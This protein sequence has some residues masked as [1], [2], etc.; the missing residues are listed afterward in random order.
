LLSSSSVCSTLP[1]EPLQFVAL[2][3]E[4][5]EALPDFADSDPLP[6]PELV[7]VLVA[8]V[9]PP[10]AVALL[11]LVAF[12]L[13]VAVCDESPP[14]PPVALLV[15]LPVFDASAVL[16]L[17][18]ALLLEV[19]QASPGSLQSPVSKATESVPTIVSS[20]RI[21][22]SS[23]PFSVPASLHASPPLLSYFCSCFTDPL[24]RLSL[25]A[26]VE[27]HA[28]ALPDVALSDP[29]PEPV[30]EAELLLLV[31]PPVALAV[32][33]LVALPLP[34]ASWLESPPLPPVAEL[35]ASPELPDV[36]VELLLPP[37]LLELESALG[38]LG[39][40]EFS[41][42]PELSV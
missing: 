14:L 39:S 4:P 32:L 10:V 13:S 27:E 12:P 34:V 23:P 42:L 8:V 5:A 16:L 31:S 36:A 26:V 2:V 11:L 28:Q 6:E 33:L 38:G 25:S 1:V 17:L 40:P 30:L 18:P 20:Q 22:P 37:L 19:E 7:A 15:A 21:P 24:E 35:V 9:S 3:S 29:L 41:E